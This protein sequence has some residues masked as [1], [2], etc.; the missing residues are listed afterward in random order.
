MIKQLAIAIIISGLTSSLSTL[1]SSP[2][3]AETVLERVARTGVLNA[4]TRTDAVPFAYINAEG[5]WVGYSIDLLGLIRDRLEQELGQEIELNLVEVTVADRIPRV[6]QG[7]VDLECGATTYTSRRA[8]QVDFS[9]GFYQTGTQ[10]LVNQEE[11]LS[12]GELRVGIL[13]GTTNAN[14]VER[15]LR[16]ARFVTLPNR[17]A[18]LQA[19]QSN[20]IDLLASDGILLEGLRQ[21]AD[22]PE[23]Y[24]IIPRSPIQPEIYGCILPKNNPELQALINQ[25]ILDFM[26]GVLDEREPDVAL[27]NRW[28]G[29]AGA[30]PGSASV[31]TDFFRQTLK[32]Y[33]EQ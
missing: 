27:F 4:G 28:F 9:V 17:M 5:E 10:F 16:V 19:L 1:I 21:T 8:R 31:L 11:N 20:Q 26:Q 3:W 32:S 14:V 29:E 7:E 15:Y 25:T 30:T 18:G 2:A 22:D 12:S 23:S 13:A 33:R 24:A 6:Q